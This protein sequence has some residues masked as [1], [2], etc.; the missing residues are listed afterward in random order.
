MYLIDNIL[1]YN[2]NIIQLIIYIILLSIK[3]NIKL[4]NYIYFIAFQLLY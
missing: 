2:I 4:I 3:L 1:Y